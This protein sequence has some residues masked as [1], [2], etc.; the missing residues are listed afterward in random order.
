[1]IKHHKVYIYTYFEIKCASL[2][3]LESNIETNMHYVQFIWLVSP[4]SF[5]FDAQIGCILNGF[6]SQVELYSFGNLEIYIYANI[7][8]TCS[9]IYILI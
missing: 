1:L 5:P 7:P 3:I 8:N 6:K 4:L 2:K 9:T